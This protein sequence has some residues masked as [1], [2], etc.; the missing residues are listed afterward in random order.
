MNIFKY[1]NPVLSVGITIS[2]F[3]AP[4]VSIDYRKSQN[5]SFLDEGSFTLLLA[6][7]IFFSLFLIYYLVKKVHA[8]FSDSAK[9]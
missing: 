2:F 5:M 7:L 4:I 6:A 8:I 3:L 1:Q 9:K